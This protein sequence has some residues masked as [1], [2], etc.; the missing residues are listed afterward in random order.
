MHNLVTKVA[1]AFSKAGNKADIATIQN[2]L[3]NIKSEIF[4]N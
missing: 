4:G 1:E 2:A 3:S